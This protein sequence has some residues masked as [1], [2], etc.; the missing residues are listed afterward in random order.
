VPRRTEPDPFAA[1]VGRRVRALR[2]AKGLNLEQLAWAGGLSSK[3]HL[4][5]LEH[6]RLVPT[7]GTL[8]GIAEQLDVDIVDLLISPAESLRHRVIAATATMSLADLQRWLDDAAVRSPPAP[9]TRT[10]VI[11]IV[12]T[13]RAPRGGV[14]Y[15]DLVAAAGQIGA[16]RSVRTEAWVKVD[17]KARLLPGAFCARVD[18]ESMEPLV[19]SGSVCLFRRPAPGNRRGRV[20]LVQHRG[21]GAPEDG[22]AYLLKMVD[23]DPESETHVLLRSLH[24]RHPPLRVDTRREQVDVVAEWVRVLGPASPAPR[25]ANSPR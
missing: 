17:A 22:G 24:P 6:G 14:P 25:P 5:D 15:V 10:P 4:S 16:G 2:E 20:F 3:G 11:D 9:P 12:H 8:S 23:R 19:P 21:A 13:P 7:I 1:A 18:G